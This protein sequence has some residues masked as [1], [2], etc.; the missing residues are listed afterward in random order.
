L[1]ENFTEYK[2]RYCDLLKLNHINLNII[3]LYFFG[4]ERRKKKERKLTI[5]F[6]LASSDFLD[7]VLLIDFW[8]MAGTCFTDVLSVLV[9]V[10][11]PVFLLWDIPPSRLFPT[12]S[13]IWLLTIFL[14]GVVTGEVA[15]LWFML[16]LGLEPTSCCPTVETDLSGG[17]AVFIFFVSCDGSRLRELERCTV[18]G[19]AADDMA[20][21][22]I[23]GL[24]AV[25]L[26][27]WAVAINDELGLCGI[28][29]W[30]VFGFLIFA[31]LGSREPPGWVREDGIFKVDTA[32]LE[33]R[34]ALL[35]FKEERL[36]DSVPELDERAMV[37]GREERLTIFDVELVDT[38][39][40][41]TELLLAIFVDIVELL[42][43]WDSCEK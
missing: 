20:Q 17:L 9:S 26:G 43:S 14:L 40:R 36:A 41:V 27:G 28:G 34:D 38:A 1:W 33:V 3:K 15:G 18:D 35:A 8:S 2:N 23:S 7:I 37:L 30:L 10:C 21:R 24:E 31:G 22:G 16:T 13:E 29:G 4:E 6:V 25:V 5:C 42:I 19:L 39:E 12:F 32:E 11:N